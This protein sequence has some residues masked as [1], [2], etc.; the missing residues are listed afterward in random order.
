MEHSRVKVG[1][2]RG[3]ADEGGAGKGGASLVGATDNFGA[4]SDIFDGWWQI[5]GWHGRVL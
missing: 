1:A 4:L 3:G 5:H 2:D